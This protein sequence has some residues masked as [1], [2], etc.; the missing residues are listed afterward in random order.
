M[1]KIEILIYVVTVLMNIAVVAKV[2]DN[3]VAKGKVF[4]SSGKGVFV[5]LFVFSLVDQL[6]FSRF[7]VLNS[8]GS[9]VGMVQNALTMTAGA[10][11]T[12]TAVT[13]KSK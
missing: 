9:I 6:V 12:H 8:A 13:L 11:G 3:A 4:L 5:L 10:M 7:D 1:N 2:R